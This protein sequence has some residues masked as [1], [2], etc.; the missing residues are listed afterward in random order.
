[1]AVPLAHR[2]RGWDVHRD[3]HRTVEAEATR[4]LGAQADR[5][6]RGPRARLGPPW[7]A[8]HRTALAATIL[9]AAG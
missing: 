5:V 2:D 1:M 7:D 9:D 4:P 6:L 8:D 3:D